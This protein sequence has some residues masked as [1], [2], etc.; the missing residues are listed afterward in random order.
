MNIIKCYKCKKF[1][2]AEKSH[3]ERIKI[4][5]NCYWLLRDKVKEDKKDELKMEN[6]Y[7]DQKIINA[8]LGFMSIN[9]YFMYNFNR[10]EIINWTNKPITLKEGRN[11]P[12][13]VEIKYQDGGRTLKIFLT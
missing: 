6:Y 7:E 13:H 2:V 1:M 8:G 12:S 11:I 5:C 3:G 9:K 10:V 4:C